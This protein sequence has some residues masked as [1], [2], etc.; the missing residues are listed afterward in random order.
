MRGKENKF[1]KIFLGLKLINSF[2]KYLEIAKF[3]I[4]FNPFL[5]SEESTCNS[6]GKVGSS[7]GCIKFSSNLKYARY[8]QLLGYVLKFNNFVRDISVFIN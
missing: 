2:I 8:S 4:L 7:T 3:E 1:L 6:L 5:S